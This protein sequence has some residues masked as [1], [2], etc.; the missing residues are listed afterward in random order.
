M[1]YDF[2]TDIPMK[3]GN[4]C[5]ISERPGFKK[6][7]VKKKCFVEILSI[8]SDALGG[9]APAA[10]ASPIA[11]TMYYLKPISCHRNAPRPQTGDWWRKRGDYFT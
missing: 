4:T 6:K 8:I 7:F 5:V 11:I 3:E 9:F 10:G 1:L 2:S